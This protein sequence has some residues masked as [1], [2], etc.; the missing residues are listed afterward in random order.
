MLNFLCLLGAN[1]AL[2]WFILENSASKQRI[3]MIDYKNEQKVWLK[4]GYFGY[5]QK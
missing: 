1:Y 3:V 2:Y 4:L 5:L